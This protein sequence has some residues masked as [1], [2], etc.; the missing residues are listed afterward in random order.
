MNI[1]DELIQVQKPG[2]YIGQEW[3]QIC[4]DKTKNLIKVLISYPD[5]YEIGM[6]NQ[7]L[8]VIYE[9]L[10]SREDMLCERC[11]APWSDMEEL[12]KKHKQPLFSLESKTPISDFDLIG[13]SLQHELNYTNIVNIL[14]L[15]NLKIWQRERGEK[16]PLIIGGGPCTLN[17]EPV[18]DFFDFFIIGE[19]EEVLIPL[20]EKVKLWKEGDI[21]RCELLEMLAKEES[22]YVPSVYE[23]YVSKE[24]FIIPDVKKKIKKAFV[25]N[26]DSLKHSTNPVVPYIQTVHDRIN[27]EVMR[28]CPMGC[29][30]CQARVYYGPA[31]SR[32]PDGIINQARMSYE[33][34]GYEELCI[35]SLSSGE[36]PYLM[37]LLESLKNTFNG[38]KVSITL[39]SLWVSSNTNSI[40]EKFLE[41]KRPALTF[42]PEVSSSKMKGII[43]KFINEEELVKIIE[44]SLERGWKKVKL[45]YMLGLPGLAEE[46]LIKMQEFISHLLSLKT[47]RKVSLRLSFATFIPKPHTSLQWVSFAKAEAVEEQVSFIRRN[48]SH[49]RVDWEMRDYK[50]SLL[51]AIFARGDRKLSEV[52]FCAWKH[53]ARF[54]SWGREFD[55]DL[56][57]NAFKISK[58]D[59]E[60]YLNTKFEKDSILPWEHID[61]GVSKDDLWKIYNRVLELC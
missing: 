14:D 55:F 34:T 20:F 48:I 19:A 49:P 60:K 9:L 2:R 42:A 6:S 43:G 46:D 50:F 5:I 29:Y 7:G 31:R 18:A 13:F 25:S 47:K 40:L 22:V 37:E 16:H 35:S 12:L 28:G 39:P 26:I 17:P 44:F 11:F 58:V 56:W 36:Y 51:E 1:F 41:S 10:N 27:I 53:G 59:F 3:N 32:K 21:K 30:F 23:T 52:I 15:G 45:Y 33:N 38:K 8:R 57:Y 24:G 4:K 61:A 54:D